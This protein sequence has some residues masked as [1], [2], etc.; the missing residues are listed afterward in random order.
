MVAEYMNVLGAVWAGWNT[1]LVFCAWLVVFCWLCA[2]A[3]LNEVEWGGV[4]CF[5]DVSTLTHT[6]QLRTLGTGTFG[7]V[8][9]VQHLPTVC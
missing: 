6:K 3:W 5:I 1:C 8:K 2:H 9:L 4:G 7:R